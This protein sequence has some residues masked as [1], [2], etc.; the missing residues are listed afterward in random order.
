ML[1]DEVHISSLIVQG[2][3]DSRAGCRG[4]CS[5]MPGLE[6]HAAADGKMVVVLETANEG[7]IVARISEIGLLERRH[8]ASTWSIHQVDKARRDTEIGEEES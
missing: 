6:I 7:E 5:A 2:M 8:V 1:S 3:P 4:L